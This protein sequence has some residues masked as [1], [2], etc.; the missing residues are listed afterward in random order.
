MSW[1]FVYAAD[2]GV[3]NAALDWVHKLVSPAT[4]ACDLCRITH[5]T[6]GRKTEW[7]LALARLPGEKRFLHRDEFVRLHPERHPEPPSVWLV[8]GGIWTRVL[9]PGDWQGIGSVAALEARL[10]EALT[11]AT[12]LRS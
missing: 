9:G 10:V 5:G 11:E 8:E 6:F 2:S 12:T 3:W 1:V 4:Y 7:S